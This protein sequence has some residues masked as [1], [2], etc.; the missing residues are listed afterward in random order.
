M[1]KAA[2]IRRTSMPTV[3]LRG[4]RDASD[5]SEDEDEGWEMLVLG[6]WSE[7]MEVMLWRRRIE[8]AMRG[9]RG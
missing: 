3:S 8:L 2:L 9:K 4:V 5:R 7:S 1:P 6:A